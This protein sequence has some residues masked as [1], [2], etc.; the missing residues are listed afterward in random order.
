MAALASTLLLLAGCQGSVAE[1]TATSTSELQQSSTGSEDV[2]SEEDSFGAD[3]RVSL[4]NFTEAAALSCEKAMTEGVTETATDGSLI[5]VMV[6][7]S[8]AI[9]SYSAAYYSPETDEYGLVF[10]ADVFVVCGAYLSF[11]LAEEA[12]VDA[13]IAAQEQ[14]DGSFFVLQDFGEFGVQG[15]S[16]FLEDGLFVSVSTSFDDYIGTT[17]I[18]YGKPS[19]D[20]FAILETAFAEF[21]E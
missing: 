8:D 3:A 14:P 17:D 20:D 19:A 1:P 7:E 4:A 10:E 11:S 18:S 13:G 2:S 21:F 9:E 16:Y 12:G 5:A 6:S 15:Q